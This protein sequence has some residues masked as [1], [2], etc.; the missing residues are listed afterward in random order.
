MAREDEESEPYEGSQYSLEGK[1]DE[2]QGEEE[3]IHMHTYRTEEIK[4]GIE[5]IDELDKDS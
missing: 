3:S 4:E 1:K 2:S 5:E